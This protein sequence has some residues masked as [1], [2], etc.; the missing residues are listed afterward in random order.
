MVILDPELSEEG[1]GEIID[2]AAASKLEL[3]DYYAR[4]LHK[5]PHVIT[6]L[7]IPSKQG[8]GVFLKYSVTAFDLAML[9]Y[10]L[11]AR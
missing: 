11:Q 8:Q 2:R 6:E 5:Q 1:Q 4:E 7:T 10:V 9:G 3:A